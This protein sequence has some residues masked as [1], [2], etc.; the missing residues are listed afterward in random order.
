MSYKG[1]VKNG[2]VVLPP[3]ANLPEGTPVEVIADEWRPEDDPFVAAVL[4]VATPEVFKVPAPRL[5]APSKKVTVPVG[6]PPLPPTA[7]VKVTRLPA[8][9]GF[10]DEVTVVELGMGAARMLVMISERAKE[11]LAAKAESPLYAAVME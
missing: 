4:K 5:P 10:W 2:V 7:A 9:A 11:V 1:K 8:G 6:M 3:E